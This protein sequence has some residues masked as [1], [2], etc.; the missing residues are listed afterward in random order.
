MTTWKEVSRL[1]DCPWW[2]GV[3]GSTQPPGLPNTTISELVT[4]KRH[5]GVPG[6]TQASVRKAAG[7]TEPEFREAKMVLTF[8]SCYLHGTGRNQEGS[9]LYPFP[10]P[11]HKRERPDP[12]HQVQTC[13]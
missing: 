6:A 8:S 2:R 13:S 9:L 5:C 12:T 7:P 10:S 11:K 4:M 1:E 3:Q